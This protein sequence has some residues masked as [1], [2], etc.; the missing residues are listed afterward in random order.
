MV[1][2]FELEE[3]VREA[4]ARTGVPGVA[5]GLWRDGALEL[6][7]GGVRELGRPEPVTVETPFRIA[8]VTKSFTATALAQAGL[9]DAR[10]CELLSH[11]A[12]LRPESP[13][14]LPEACA[15]LWSYSNA[16]YWRAAAAFPDYSA[17]VREL[18]LEPLGLAASG[19]EEPERPARGHVQQGET[20]HRP[21]ADDAYP[22]ERRASGGLWSTAGDLVAYGVAHGDGFAELHEPRAEALGASYALGWWV[23]D[24]VLEHEGSVAGYQSLLLV[25]PE[26]RLVL[27]VLTNSW[28]G[29]GLI[30]RVVEALGVH[31]ASD[32]LSR[33]GAAGADAV[34]RYAL[35]GVE[36]LVEPA[37]DGLRV[38]ESE[39]DP[40]TGGRRTLRYP[41]APVGDG[42]WGFA[43][44]TLM[45]H[46]LD[47]P[48][49]G[50]ARIGWVAL[51]RA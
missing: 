17:A 39:D 13:A 37:P 19:F 7:A 1:A 49:P 5:A 9:L 3:A 11:T 26:Q 22:V 15:G 44:G 45:S 50:V 40:V 43:R 24:G 10:R 30:R 31:R 8:S 34:G 16:G 38:S 36:A 23:R 46:R 27:A 41:A 47:F 21:V 25:A 32:K 2:A 18:V 48:R 29:S 42:L 33:D 20:G 51:P 35:D 6:A 12:G 4:R 28:R 14:P